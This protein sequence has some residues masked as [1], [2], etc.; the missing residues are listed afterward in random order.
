MPR[1]AS[2]RVI[3]SGLL[4]AFALAGCAASAAPT[5][6]TPV[7][8]ASAPDPSTIA[9]AGTGAPPAASTGPIDM[10][11]ATI[12]HGTEACAANGVSL[13]SPDPAGT[14]R[15]RGATIDCTMTFDDPRVSGHK[16]GGF[17]VDAWGT[18]EDGVMVQW[19]GG[20]RITNDQGAWDGWFIGVYTST[21]GDR[22]QAWYTGSGAYEGLAFQETIDQL[23]PSGVYDVTGIIYPGTI[24]APWEPAPAR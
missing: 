22:I 12:V 11:G 8:G 24:P 23:S 21:G 1:S 15:S 17:E 6:G 18:I 3:A 14:H 4:L 10:H 7:A 20:R 19:G 9:N 5:P 13:S 2:I 16:T